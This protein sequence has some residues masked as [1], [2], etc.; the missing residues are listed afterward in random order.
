MLKM[1]R[2]K[3]LLLV[4]VAAGLIALIGREC[5]LGYAGNNERSERMSDDNHQQ[6][7][8][9]QIEKLHQTGEFDK[10]LEISTRALEANPSNLRAYGLRWRLIADMFSEAAARKRIQSEI[11]SF[12]RTQPENPEVL[13]T[14][15]W[16]Y[17]GLPLDDWD[18][19]RSLFDTMLQYPGTEIHLL[20][21]LGLAAQSEDARE[22]WHFYQRVI[23]ELTVSDPIE[24]SW[25]FLAYEEMLWLAK[26]DRSLVSD[27]FL[28]EFL[29]RYLKDL[30]YNRQDTQRWFGGAYTEAVEWRLKFHVRLDKALKILE[31]A[32]SRLEEKEEQEWFVEAY[33]E[34]VEEAHKYIARL[35]AEVYFRQERWRESY[36]GLVANPPGYSESLWRRLE[37][38][39]YGE[40]ITNYFWLLGRSAEGIG[41]WEKARRYYA[42]AHF[43]P[44]PH[45]ESRAGLERVYHQI[46]R[47]AADTFEAFLEDTEAEYRIRED[48]DREEIRQKIIKNRLS[49]K[50]T[51]FSLETLEGEVYTLSAACGKVV[52][53][54]V[55][56]SWCV[57][58]NATIPEVEMIYDRFRGVDDV[59]IWG[60]N[61]GETP[62][63]VQ[64]FLEEHQT[65]WP[66]LLDR[67]KQ[68]REA[69][70][71]KGL[72]FFILIDRAGKWQ[73]SFIGSNLIGGQPLI[74]MIEALLED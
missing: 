19:P 44:T 68:V 5:N 12:L 32:E 16:G 25:Y 51:D 23:D 74:W 13:R 14:A 28:D 8:A 39:M 56:A 3:L 57:P 55:G 17:R 4:G 72:P 60:I 50:A 64:K 36:D 69:Y 20:A 65:P 38:T 27:D 30:L 66:I 31:N 48:T 61:D 7:L 6:D 58:C 52:L 46:E 21:L 29:D 37:Q 47:G 26:E 62:E 53:L 73:Y 35:R 15:Y 49:K 1:N 33:E 71:I 67:R 34:S 59:A 9:T 2:V 18:V 11:E 54:D 41:K 10:A 45:P 70:Q 43:A 24:L 63:Q 42:D 40:S 22:K